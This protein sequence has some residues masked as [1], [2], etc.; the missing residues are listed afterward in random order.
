M[1]HWLIKRKEIFNILFVGL[2]FVVSLLNYAIMQIF[3]PHKIPLTAIPLFVAFSRHA[4]IS[5]IAVVVIGLFD[6]FFLNT[7]LGFFPLIYSVL[8]YVSFVLFNHRKNNKMSTI[9][10][11]ILFALLNI[12]L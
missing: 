5:L 10:F 1:L 2:C 3:E 4:P 6:D 8:A 7:Y 12:I 9:V 11:F